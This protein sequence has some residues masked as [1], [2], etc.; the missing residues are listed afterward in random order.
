M[1]EALREASTPLLERH[2]IGLAVAFGSRARGTER[3]GSDLDVGVEHAS[4]RR[5]ELLQ[6]GRLQEELSQLAGV[7]VDV[8]DLAA[9]DCI[10][11]IEVARDGRVLFE[12]E[13]G[14]WTDFVARALIDHDDVAGFLPALVAGVGRAARKAGSAT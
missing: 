2:G 1:I 10:A 5:L 12:S 4:R 14:R 11:R 9:A 7:Q 13:A 8:V 6:L 3:P